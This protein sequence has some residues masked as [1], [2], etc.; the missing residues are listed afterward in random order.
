MHQIPEAT[1][2][3]AK[4]MTPIFKLIPQHLWVIDG[5]IVSWNKLVALRVAEKI[6]S[7]GNLFLIFDCSAFEINLN[8]DYTF[9]LQNT[10][11]G[12]KYCY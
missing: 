3:K 9:A 11:T 4:M 6:A 5:L 10:H 2:C 12:W 8:Y 1:A 7:M